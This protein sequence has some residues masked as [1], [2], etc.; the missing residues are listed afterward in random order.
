MWVDLRAD[1]NDYYRRN[2]G[3][4]EPEVD[5]LQD[6]LDKIHSYAPL[7]RVFE[8]GAGNGWRLRKIEQRY[9]GC[10]A[11]GLDYSDEAVDAS[12][13]MVRH[14]CAPAELPWYGTASFDVVI[15]G[16]FTYLLPRTH[17][18]ELVAGVDRIVRDGGHVVV[19]DFLHPTP[20]RVPYT[21]SGNLTV[22][23]HDVS[24]LFT[25]NPQYVLV[26]RRLV[27]HHG[28]R[29]DNSNPAKWIVADA[30]MKLS[31]ELAYRGQ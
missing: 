21:H 4:H 17:V 1:C 9:D 10:R 26:D 31:P 6:T 25:A 23:K 12:D 24:G 2:M 29:N 8:I 22:Y 18:M 28:H 16:F 14:G 5:E 20:V 13:G 19:L 11:Y 30:V 3:L 15:L 27:D 7:E